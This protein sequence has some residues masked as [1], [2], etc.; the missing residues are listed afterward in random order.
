MNVLIFNIGLLVIF[1]GVIPAYAENIVYSNSVQTWLEY[2]CNDT[3]PSTWDKSNPDVN[4]FKYF[5][6]TDGNICHAVLSTFD[7]REIQNIENVT[8]V[9]LSIDSKPSLLFGGSNPSQYDTQCNLF[10]FSDYTDGNAIYHTPQNYNSFSCTGNSGIQEIKIPFTL[11][12]ITSF[13][14]QIANGNYFFD[15]MIFPNFGNNLNQIIQNNH[16]YTIGKYSQELSIAGDG[17]DCTVIA[18]SNWCNLFN[19]PWGGVKKALGADYFG[20]WFYVLVFLPLPMSVF[21]ITRNGAYAGFVCLP[22]IL[23]I[24]TIEQ[25]VIEIS[26]SMILIAAAFGFY[27]IL[28]KRLHE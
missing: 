4:R 3:I 11:S 10:Y 16:H 5:S 15:I 14:N 26:L 7:L 27:E 13:E 9:S 8:S 25:R 12:Q 28:R 24:T 18:A 17:F 6:Y 1:T 19:D 20:E 21:L 22:L 2:D 23:V